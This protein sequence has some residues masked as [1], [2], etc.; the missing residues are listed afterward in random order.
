MA[1]NE[2][3]TEEPPKQNWFERRVDGRAVRIAFGADLREFALL[4][5]VFAILDVFI[6]DKLTA[7]WLITNGLFGILL[8]TIGAYIEMK[9]DPGELQR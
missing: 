6:S 7:R 9:I 8:W 4:R 3:E 2:I 5:L 1:E